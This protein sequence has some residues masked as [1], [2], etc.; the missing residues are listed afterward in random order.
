[1]AIEPAIFDTPAIV[2]IFNQYMPEEYE[3][4]FDAFWM[5]RHFGFLANQ[6]LLPFVRS[7][8]EMTE[9]IR[10]ALADRSW[11]KDERSV[12]RRELL[13]PLDGHATERL[14]R[15]AVRAAKGVNHV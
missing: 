15:A 4:F 3:R 5:S 11:M 14:A 8:G 12:I 9:W 2:P 13:G 7:V 6:N 1:M 10:R